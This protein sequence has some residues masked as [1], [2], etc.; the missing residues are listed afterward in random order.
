MQGCNQADPADLIIING[1]ILTVDPDFTVCE[2]L[3]VRGDRIM[4]VG[5]NKKIGKLQGSRSRI[6]DAGGRTVVPGI[7]DAHLHPEGAS[8]SELENEVPDIRSIGELMEWITSRIQTGREGEWII[9]PK[10]FFTRL[11]DLRPPTLEEL[12]SVAP[13]NPVFLNGSYG[14]MINSEAMRVSGINREITHE[15]VLKDGRTGRPTGFLRA[16]AF[17]LLQ[18]PPGKPLSEQEKIEALQAMMHRYH[19]YGITSL[20]SGASNPGQFDRYRELS[21]EG[22]LTMRITQ[23]IVFPSGDRDNPERT[24]EALREKG[25]VTGY[26]D[27]WVR[28][29]ALKVFLDGGILTGTAY[30]R[31]PWG[32]KAC[33]YFGINDRDYRGVINYSFAELLPI[34]QSANRHGW[35]FTAHCTGGGGVDLLLDV[36]EEVN[37]TKPVA[38]RRFSIIHGNFFTG[39]AI[40]RMNE[41]N[42]YADMQPAWFYK[43]A[44]AMELILGKE[45]IRTFHPYRS[46]VDSGVMVNG[47]SDHM[48][49]WDADASINPYNP[50]LGMWTMVSRTTERG[51]TI[52]PSEAI[53]REEALRIYTINNAYAS[54][55]ESL[56]GSLE[57]GKLADMAILSGELMN[58]P[59]DLIRDITSELTIVGGTVVYS[60]GKVN[61]DYP[62]AAAELETAW[63]N[64]NSAS[65]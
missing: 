1:K 42:V 29:G 18:L 65:D 24:L 17:R 15:G 27:E 31:E 43:D 62:Q 22:K 20:C 58:C 34:V 57:P 36:Y 10:L 41:M 51:N 60:S 4:A 54:F 50:F 37:K 12:D 25:L 38:E 63:K 52:V 61:G 7:I 21:N 59:A 6:I 47:G 55:E 49:G 44:D 30:L 56:K 19:R 32:E 46:L 39:R 45:R 53:T 11:A 35:K 13:R 5:S 8:R 33:G 23:N 16:S 2:A 48:A 3:A 9:H 64:W 40:Q 14:G 26:G 28:I